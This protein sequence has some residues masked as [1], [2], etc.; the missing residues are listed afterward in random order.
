MAAEKGN[1]IVSFDNV[2]F[3]FNDKKKII[4]E[5]ADFTVR[6]NTKITIMGQNGAGKSTIFKLLM[7]EL[8]PES[9]KVNIVA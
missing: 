6:E 5:C 3:S 7:R 2:C 9:G 8:K 1:V 4:L